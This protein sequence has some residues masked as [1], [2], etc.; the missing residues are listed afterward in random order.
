[1]EGLARQEVSVTCALRPIGLTLA[2]AIALAVSLV[3]DARGQLRT[4]PVASGFD[5]PLGLIPY[6]GRT[7]TFLVFEQSGRV[8]VLQAGA[9]TSPDFVDLRSDIASGGEQ[10]LLGMALAPDF[11]TSGRFF[12]SFTNRSGD[13]VI[14]R[15]KRSASNP[16]QAD[17]AS[18]VDLRWPD[19]QR[20]IRQPFTNHNGGH[21]AFGPDGY[22]YIGLGDGG[23]SNDPMHRAQD[24]AS[25]LGKM[26][27]I[28]VSVPDDDA[29]GYVVPNNNP[30]VG[31]SDVLGEIWA[32]GLRNP[33]RWSFDD[34]ARGGTGALV[35]GDVGQNAREEIDYE[36]RGVGGRNYGWRNREGSLSNV[37]SRPPFSQPLQEPMWDYTREVGRSVTGGVVYRGTA[38]GQAY[39]GRYFFA[40]FVTSRVWSLALIVDPVTREA[41]ADNLID[42]TADLGAAA[43]SPASFAVD[44]RGEI[45]VLG[46]GGT[47]YRLVGPDLPATPVPP[48]TS[49]PLRPHTDPPIGRAR[50]RP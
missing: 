46:Y 20:V 27:R 34:P 30:F 45:Y 39:V 42:H 36:P 40:D 31:R 7:D 12:L 19:G 25:L 18:R 43:A 8:R 24:P 32:F 33:W 47:I 2:F 16:L 4:T 44:A 48:T 5:R 41:R 3:T 22:L 1:M 14:A 17:A 50:P 15:M 28:D 13:S 49:R 6:P 38:L 37:T 10:G 9:I 26:L 21:I 35:I 11:T 23:S 29:N